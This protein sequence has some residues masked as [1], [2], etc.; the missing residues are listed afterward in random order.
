MNPEHS[1]IEITLSRFD[2]IYRPGET[3]SGSI[4]ITAK[5]GWSHPALFIDAVGIATLSGEGTVPRKLLEER[6][7]VAEAGR[8]DMGV[9]SFPFSFPLSGLNGK[10]LLETYHGAYINVN[11]T[12]TVTIERGRMKRNLEKTVEFIVEVPMTKKSLEEGNV[13]PFSITPETLEKVKSSQVS[14]VKPFHIEGKLHRSNCLINLPFTGEIT[15]VSS[16][17]SIR[18]IE[19]QL[20]RVES[21]SKALVSKESASHSAG[22]KDYVVER[23]EIESLQ[24]ASND[25]TKNIA[26]PLYMILPR[27]YCCPTLS[28]AQFKVEFEVN[29]IVVF[30]DGYC[31]TECFPITL[32]RTQ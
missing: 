21:I 10:M 19:L 16:E 17:Q 18:R 1:S 27:V 4:A 29:L 20:V 9:T 24:M 15:I 11:Y 2:R 22:S 5:D 3:L 12:L 7:A 30:D 6:V 14:K 28:T 23:T 8:L 31:V 25:V 32:H 13:V 26:V